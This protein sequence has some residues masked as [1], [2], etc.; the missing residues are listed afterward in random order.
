DVRL[1]ASPRA[2]LALLRAAQA[3]ALV[4]GRSYV[5]PHDVK[6]LAEPVLAHRLILAPEAEVEGRRPAE[7]VAAVA[8]SVR[9]PTR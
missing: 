6:V 9:A 3:H 4:D 7:V 5:V 1:G 8:A 2:S